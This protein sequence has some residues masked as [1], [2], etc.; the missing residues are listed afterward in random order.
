MI[1]PLSLCYNMW[2]FDLFHHPTWCPPERH[3]LRKLFEEAN[4]QEWTTS[5]GWVDEVNDH[6]EWH[7][8]QCNKEGKVVKL[9]LGNNGLSGRN[10]SAIGSLTSLEIID[11]HDSDLKKS[12]PSKIGNLSNLL[13]LIISFNKITGTVPPKTS[14][15]PKLELLNLHNNRLQSTVPPLWLKGQTIPSFI[16]YCGS[17]S[18]FDSLLNCPDCT[19]GWIP[20]LSTYCIFASKKKGASLD[21]DADRDWVYQFV[22][23]WDTQDCR[24]TSDN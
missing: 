24:K 18:D 9:T 15:L 13:S 10:S 2:G 6:C 23:P 22:C 3:F 8:A 19:I 16:V 5:T 12:I 14:E 7:N 11:L 20:V 1:D 4:G 17:P 21:F